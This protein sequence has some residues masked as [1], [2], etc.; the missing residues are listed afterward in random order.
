MKLLRFLKV[1][2]NPNEVQKQF[3]T[4]SDFTDDTGQTK[5]IRLRYIGRD[6]L[7]GKGANREKKTMIKSRNVHRLLDD[8]ENQ[9]QEAPRCQRL[10]VR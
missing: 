10:L 5:M 3:S 8:C 6:A 1:G 4:E 7:S 2:A 9:Q